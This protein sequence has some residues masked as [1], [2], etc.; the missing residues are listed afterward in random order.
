MGHDAGT[1]IGPVPP[2]PAPSGSAAPDRWALAE[3]V[4]QLRPGG[5]AMGALPDGTAFAVLATE[6]PAEP[7]T[8]PLAEIWPRIAACDPSRPQHA[9]T[10]PR[11]EAP[12]T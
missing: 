1:L 11:A 12:R 7:P 9:G 10:G 6:Q 2:A 3:A 4:A 8:E 5:A